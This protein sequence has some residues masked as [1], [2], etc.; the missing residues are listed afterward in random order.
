[1]TN[2]YTLLHASPSLKHTAT[3]LLKSFALTEGNP[4]HSDPRSIHPGVHM[5]SWI[6]RDSWKFCSSHTGYATR[7]CSSI[8]WSCLTP[9]KGPPVF[10]TLHAQYLEP[11]S[12]VLLPSLATKSRVRALLQ[13]P[14][15]TNC[16]PVPLWSLHPLSW[17]HHLQPALL[18]CVLALTCRQ[19]TA[20]APPKSGI[21]PL[22]P[23]GATQPQT[24][25]SSFLHQAPRPQSHMCQHHISL[26]TA[27]APSGAGRSRYQETPPEQGTTNSSWGVQLR[28]GAIRRSDPTRAKQHL[29]E[30]TNV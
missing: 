21:S 11:Y 28:S 26:R 5:E 12:T 23:L 2:P 25:S 15:G 22:A 9:P 24:P 20:E 30:K 7:T 10:P 29:H 19:V 1:M 18:P 17:Q 4:S 8:P 14:G 16:H 3:L 13:L 27:P 6:S